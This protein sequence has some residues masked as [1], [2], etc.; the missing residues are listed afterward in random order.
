M[1][2]LIKTLA[3]AVATLA[4]AGSLQAGTISGGVTFVGDYSANGTPGDLTT[5]TEVTPTILVTLGGGDLTGAVFGSFLT[6]IGVNG[7]VASNVGAELWEVQV[8]LDTYTLTVG[9][10]LQT[11]GSSDQI[12][13]KG[14]G[15][16]Q[17]NGGDDTGGSWQLSF[18]ETGAFFG[19]QST[20][21]TNVPD[22]GAT[23]MLFGLGVL[24]LGMMRRKA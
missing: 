18:G 24:G 7:N 22:G 20:S 5:A 19:F 14:T 17:K 3:G 21:G 11:L 10:A 1:K 16:I 6:P 15:T 23:A 2:S 8:G 9:T 13:L 12:A 4:L